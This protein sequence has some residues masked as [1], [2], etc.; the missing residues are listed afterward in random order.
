MAWVLK[1]RW[2]DVLALPEEERPAVGELSVTAAQGP[3]ANAS[4]TADEASCPLVA[5]P[6][7]L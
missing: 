5:R 4:S 2:D 1:M 3:I 7:T 6:E